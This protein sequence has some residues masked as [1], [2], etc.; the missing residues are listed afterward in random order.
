MQDMT[1]Y[2]PIRVALA[3]IRR[4]VFGLLLGIIPFALIYVLANSSGSLTS[5]AEGMQRWWVFVLVGVFTLV[6]LSFV[7]G[8]VGRVISAFV[9]GC[10]FR[11]G[12]EGM[13][14][15]VPEQG[16]FGRFKVME[17]PYKWEEVE[18]IMNITR[19]VNF[20]PIASELNI[21][22]YGGKEITIERYYFSSSAK[23]LCADFL[24]VRA[25][26]GK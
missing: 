5:D 18:R 14:I 6:S 20:I 11:A 9:R 1:T 16:W 24:A 15:R 4:I 12:A 26:A 21:R 8:G 3:G 19:S 13:A 25:R 17:Y 10:Y 2:A 23:K 7:L 22:V